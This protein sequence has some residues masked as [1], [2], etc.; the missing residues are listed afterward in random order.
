M[1]TNSFSSKLQD[2]T[3]APFLKK[4]AIV[5]IKIG[6]GYLQQVAGII[7]FLV[8]GKTQEDLKN[9]EEKIKN[10]TELEPWMAAVATLQV[11]IR[12]VFEEADKEGLVEYKNLEESLKEDLSA[13]TDNLPSEQS[14]E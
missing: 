9:I 7:S 13:I 1:S 5:N 11:L 14:P 12:T 3:L 8:E 10:K 2:E 4:D 6:T